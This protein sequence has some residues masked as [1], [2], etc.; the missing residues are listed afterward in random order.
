MHMM[1]KKRKVVA[2]PRLASIQGKTSINRKFVNQRHNTATDMALLRSLFGNISDMI[3]Q[4][5]GPR[6][7]AKDAM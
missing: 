3:T 5:N 2:P 4:V 7:M 6:E 1:P